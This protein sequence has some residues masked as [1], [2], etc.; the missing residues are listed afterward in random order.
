MND[1]V[2]CTD[3]SGAGLIIVAGKSEWWGPGVQ[4]STKLGERWEKRPPVR[5][6]EG[7][8]LSVEHVWIVCQ[9]RLGDGTPTLFAGVDP[10]ARPGGRSSCR[11]P[12]RG[13]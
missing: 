4:V 13:C 7:R 12:T 2:Y 9:G 3:G 1:V 10:A 5:F 6:A 11:R 8:G